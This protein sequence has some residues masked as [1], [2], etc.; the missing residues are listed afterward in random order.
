MSQKE[1]FI[2]KA[3]GKREPWNPHKLERSLRAAKASEELVREIVSHIE[4]DL[5]D[6]LRTSDIYAHAFSLLKRYDRP[7]AAQYS[8][9]KAIAALGP[10]G[11]PFERFIA[12]IL[13]A[14]GYRTRVGQIVQGFCVSH[15]VDVIAE[16]DDER[17]LVEAKFHNSPETKSDVKVALYVAARFQDIEKLLA[18]K[19]S[20][21]H[22]T[23]AWLITN[24][25]FTSQA[26]Q[27]GT[28]AGL[29]LT[30]WNHPKGKTLQDL[31]QETETHPVTCLT[32]LTSVHKTQL[33]NEGIVLCGDVVRNTGTLSK[34]GLNRAR[35]ASVVEEGGRLCPITT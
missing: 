1:V 23:H 22:F 13:N 18:Q 24:T 14:Q 8:L 4:K 26:I 20:R 12:K 21:E 17:I 34:M 31:V 35:I 11:F 6:G 2:I 7:I 19:E 9:R 28:C 5:R 3:S 29:A 32:T 10:S 27:Y 15:E 25:S 30:G 33:L 16:K